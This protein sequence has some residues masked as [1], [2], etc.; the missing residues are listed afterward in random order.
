MDNLFFQ[1][2]KPFISDGVTKNTENCMNAL[3]CETFVFK[4][5]LSM[6]FILYI[7]EIFQKS[8][9]LTLKC[10]ELALC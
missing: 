9:S 10:L 8:W 2:H 4:L 5:R 1:Y 7:I 3:S 6:N